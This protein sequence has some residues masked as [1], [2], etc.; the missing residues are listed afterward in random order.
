MV[1]PKTI[2]VS[3]PVGEEKVMGRLKVVNGGGGLLRIE[4]VKTSCG[5]TVASVEPRTLDAGQ[6]AS[7]TLV[8]DVPPV[9][10]KRVD[11]LITS[12]DPKNP[13]QRAVFTMSSARPLP[14]VDV[15][16]Q[17]LSWTPTGPDDRLRFFMRTYEPLGSSEWLASARS[18][19]TA[20][21]VSGGVEREYV[22]F[23]GKAVVREYR[24]TVQSADGGP[25]PEKARV[26]QFLGEGSSR[27]NLEIPLVVENRPPV[28]VAPSMLFANVPKE[29][30]NIR[31]LV[32]FVASELKEPLDVRPETV[33]TG[34]SYRTRLREHSR[35]VFE[36]EIDPASFGE[37]QELPSSLEFATNH[38]LAPMVKARLVL[39]FR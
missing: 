20:L 18:S 35:Q 2:H 19:D 8:G 10:E 11:V 27:P 38:P 3:A 34:L 22:S 28:A 12:N 15:A 33:M 13:E 7:I 21:A 23:G 25:I 29:E 39:H 4:S 1:L 5:C 32:S 24:Y 30:S 6:E 31:F 17:S 37:N 36:V 26:I 9:G 16:P 14:H